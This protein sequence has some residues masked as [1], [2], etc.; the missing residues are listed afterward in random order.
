MVQ[1]VFE[2]PALNTH[3]EEFESGDA[4]KGVNDERPLSQAILCQAPNKKSD[5]GVKGGQ[6]GGLLGWGQG[7]LPRDG[8]AASTRRGPARPSGGGWGVNKALR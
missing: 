1:P 7:S 4:H 6:V 8:C 5:L 2:R 3:M